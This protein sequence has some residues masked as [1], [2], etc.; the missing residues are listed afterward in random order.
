MKPQV[1]PWEQ[2]LREDKAPTKKQRQ[3]AMAVEQAGESIVITDVDGLI[4][5]VNPA[6]E[7][8]TGYRREEVL[9]Q[10]PRMLKSGAHNRAFYEDMWQHLSRGQTWRGR[11]I[12]KRKDG[13]LYRES[14]TQYQFWR[15]VLMV[16]IGFRVEDLVRRFR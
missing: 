6:F 14:A 2:P 7:G 10:N 1:R 13:T 4:T 12:N 8:T 11:L 15:D 3:L 5:Y 9:G 16:Y